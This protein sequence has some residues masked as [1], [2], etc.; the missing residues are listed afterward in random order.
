MP[1]QGSQRK[2]VRGVVGEIEP[3][4][5]TEILATGVPEA[6]RAG[7]LQSIEFAPGGRL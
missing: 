6:I 3:T 4:L 5:Q 1:A 2:R 7:G